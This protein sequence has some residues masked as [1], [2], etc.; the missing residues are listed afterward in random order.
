M[1][2]VFLFAEL[3]PHYQNFPKH[4]LKIFLHQTI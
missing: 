1:Y 2:S 3:E 4:F